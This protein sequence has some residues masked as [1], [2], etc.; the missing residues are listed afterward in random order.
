MSGLSLPLAWLAPVC[1]LIAFVYSSVGLGG[2]SSYLAAMALWGVDYQLMP[3]LALGLNLI[4]AGGGSWH[5]YKAGHHNPRL[6]LPLVGA[7]VPAAFIASRIPIKR[8]AFY[9]LLG[10]LLGLVAARMVWSRP[11]PAPEAS[12]APPTEGRPKTGLLLVVGL[13]LGAVAGITGIGGGIYLV[14]VLLSL[15]LASAKGAAAVAAPFIV[16]NSIAGLAGR[17]SRDLRLP[18]SSVAVLAVSVF[19]AGQ[20]GARLGATSFRSVTVRR[21]F[22]LIVGFVA[23]RLLWRAW[24]LG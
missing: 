14:P 2:G 16:V 21:I 11:S 20:L 3:T 1:A 12:I 10:V 19:A 15:R 18:W 6:F 9:G 7:S 13:L 22:G 8:D 24:L 4:V 5:Y 23:L 17:I